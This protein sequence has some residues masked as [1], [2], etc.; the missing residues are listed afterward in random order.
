MPL[1]VSKL[2]FGLGK[3]EINPDAPFQKF[4]RLWG[5]PFTSV[6]TRASDELYNK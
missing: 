4:A 2:P 1:T 6:P 5:Y 3:L